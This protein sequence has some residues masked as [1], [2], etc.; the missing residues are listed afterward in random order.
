MTKPVRG[1]FVIGRPFEYL[2]YVSVYFVFC[3][4]VSTCLQAIEYFCVFFV[5]IGFCYC[6]HVQ[7]TNVGYS[8]DTGN[9]F[10]FSI[11]IQKD[12][13]CQVI[14][15]KLEEFAE[16]LTE[17]WKNHQETETVRIYKV[18]SP[19]FDRIHPTRTIA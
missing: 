9:E 15:E 6:V 16:L 1:N 14:D 4:N 18:L 8:I 5:V 2:F 19:L 3:V 7:K 10:V 17:D 12:G 11:F 13:I